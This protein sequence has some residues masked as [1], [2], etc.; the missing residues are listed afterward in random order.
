MTISVVAIYVELL[1]FECYVA[2]SCI[3]QP[4]YVIERIVL[5][6]VRRAGRSTRTADGG[7]RTTCRGPATLEIKCGTALINVISEQVGGKNM[8][9]D[10]RY[11]D[12][13]DQSTGIKDNTLTSPRHSRARDGRHGSR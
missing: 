4:R 12:P 10:R 11:D 6:V 9:L 8:I 2:Y 13:V 1:V 5:V 3:A 7:A